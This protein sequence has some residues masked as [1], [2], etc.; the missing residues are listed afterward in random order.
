MR[1]LHTSDWHLGKYLEHQSRLQE[2]SAFIDELV[3]IA[4]EQAVDLI[5]V[6]GD[7]YDTM[8]P[9]AAA[10]GLFYQAMIRLSDGGRRAVLVIGGNHDSAE[11]LSAVSPVLAELP[12]I[13]LGAPKSVAQTG[14]YAHFAVTEAGEGYVCLS[15]NGEE[16]VVLT[17]PYPSERRLN[18]VFFQEGDGEGEL[19]KSYSDK[20]SDILHTLSAKFRPDTV[21][22]ITGH[23]YVAGGESSRSERDIQLGGVYA[24]SPAAF[25]ESAQ[26]IAMGHLHRAQRIPHTVPHAYYCGSPIQYDKSEAAYAKCV[27]VAELHPG[28]EAAVEKVYLRNYKPILL[29]KAS[30]VEEAVAMC[31]TGTE[32]GWISLE[33]ETDRPMASSEIKAMRTAQKDLI[34]I[35]PVI[36]NTAGAGV[37]EGEAP[38]EDKSITEEFAA[39]YAQRRQGSA[40]GGAVMELFARLVA[41]EEGDTDETPATEG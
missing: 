40:P 31:E 4:A 18:E 13:V 15:L 1:I 37:P 3:T 19:Q 27:Y 2:Q 9:P 34:E 12:V 32:N 6:A 36:R 30:S 41:F 10:E 38:A 23:F 11:R 17:L 26:Y 33:I 25:P 20:I 39:Y 22:I 7:V 5:L 35:T 8:N 16:A 28:R 29:W 21:N 24:V 14:S